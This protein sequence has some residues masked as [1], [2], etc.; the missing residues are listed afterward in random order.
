LE[1]GLLNYYAR[2]TRKAVQATWSP[3]RRIPV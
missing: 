3:I 2:I 1:I